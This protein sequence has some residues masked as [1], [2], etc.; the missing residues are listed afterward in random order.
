M[1]IT[2]KSF[3]KFGDD[4]KKFV[5]GLRKGVSIKRTVDNKIAFS[6]E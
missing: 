3:E 6:I 4:L 1:H 2:D 5:Q